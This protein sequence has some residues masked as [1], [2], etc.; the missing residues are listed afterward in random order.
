MFTKGMVRAHMKYPGG[1]DRVYGMTGL[2]PRRPGG[3]RRELMRGSLRR[4][5]KGE[6][7]SA[8]GGLGPAASP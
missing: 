8:R 6:H 7:R 3:Q 1:Q 5:H 4:W 2:A